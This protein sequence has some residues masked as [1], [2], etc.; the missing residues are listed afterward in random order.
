MC[1][2]GGLDEISVGDRHR[3]RVRGAEPADYADLA[4]NCIRSEYTDEHLSVAGIA[5]KLNINRSY[6]C[7]VFKQHTGRSPQQ[8]LLDVRLSHAAELMTLYGE[9]ITV[10]ANSVGYHDI[11]LFSEMF[12]KHFGVSPREYRK[13]RR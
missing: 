13:T 11:C 1:G 4:V 5:E 8:Y 3:P 7:T 10:A 12:K 2:R 9:S 6:L